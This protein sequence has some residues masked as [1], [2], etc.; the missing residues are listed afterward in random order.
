MSE[1]LTLLSIDG[2]V[3]RL[4]LNRPERHNSL[5]PALIDSLLD[6]LDRIAAE[7]KIL[8]LQAAGRSFS[9][10]GDVAGFLAVDRG[11]RAEYAAQLV[12]GLNQAILKLLDL[13]IPVIGRIHG[14]VTGGSLGFLLACDLAA[15]T[16]NAFIQPYYTAVGFSPDGG[17]TALL[18]ARI[19][20]AKARE[21]QLLNRRITAAEAVRLG[22]ATTLVEPE[23]LDETIAQ[24]VAALLDKRPQ[25]M[26]RTKK[27]LSSPE[28]RVAV[29]EGLEA[30]KLSFIEQIDSEEA[31]AGMARFLAKSA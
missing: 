16:P 29:V 6:N 27:L 3:A 1:P 13:T 2:P 21:I 12:G 4:T 14:P 24:W 9:T 19:G 22:L 15:I 17:W 5:V 30:E 28:R 26:C 10:G 23:N 31:Q 25:A 20:A 18:P 8:V 11:R 7:A